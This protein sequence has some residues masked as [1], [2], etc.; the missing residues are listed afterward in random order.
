M[1]TP[2]DGNTLAIK[3]IAD[4]LVG[5]RSWVRTMLVVSAEFL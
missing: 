2:H 5:G 4:N 3:R 1:P